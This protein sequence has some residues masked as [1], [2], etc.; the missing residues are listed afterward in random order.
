ML[1]SCFFED[2]LIDCHQAILIACLVIDFL[3]QSNNLLTELCHFVIERSTS[4]LMIV[5]ALADDSWL[6][7]HFIVELTADIRGN[8]LWSFYNTF[9][10]V[11]AILHYINT[12]GVGASEEVNGLTIGVRDGSIDGVRIGIGFRT[13]GECQCSSGCEKD[14][15]H[16]DL[17]IVIVYYGGYRYYRNN[18]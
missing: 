1:V 15:F 5:D 7:D 3:D 11:G 14:F 8:A 18:R 6:K 4:N 9:E 12:Q 17:F 10:L 16:F 13:C 2:S